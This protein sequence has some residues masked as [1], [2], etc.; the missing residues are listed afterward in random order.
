MIFYPNYLTPYLLSRALFVPLPKLP[1]N[2]F[3]LTFE[4]RHFSVIAG[5]TCETYDMCVMRVRRMRRV[6]HVTQSL[7]IDEL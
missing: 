6:R 1:G 4:M 3:P 5:R 7:S 2:L